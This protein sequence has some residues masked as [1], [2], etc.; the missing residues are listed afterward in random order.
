[1]TGPVDRDRVGAVVGTPMVGRLSV[2]VVEEEQPVSEALAHVLQVEGFTVEWATTGPLALR[3]F[4]KVRP[5]LV[6][7]DLMLP[8]LDGIAVCRAIRRRSTVP[9]ILITARDGDADAAQGLAAGADAHVTKPCSGD[10]LHATIGPLLDRAASAVSVHEPPPGA[11]AWLDLQVVRTRR[12][13]GLRI[14]RHEH[15][16][17][18]RR[19]R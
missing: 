7:L 16:K 9:I 4:D 10:D 11:G 17:A 8:G 18:G 14:A 1:M 5:D 12:H 15:L 6:L 13:H 2:L 3:M 19:L